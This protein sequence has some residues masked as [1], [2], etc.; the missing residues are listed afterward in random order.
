MLYNISD[1]D[2]TLVEQPNNP[3][4]GVKILRG[5]WKDVVVVYGAVSVK[6]SPELDCATLSFNFNIQD[7]GE[8]TIDELEQDEAFKN[9]LGDLLQYIIKDGLKYAEENNTSI[10]G[11]GNDESTT[12]TDT[13]QSS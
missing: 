11:I 9:Y 12:D 8:S 7:P 3:L 2:Y 10:I 13:E 4:H 6:E 1:D 5:Q